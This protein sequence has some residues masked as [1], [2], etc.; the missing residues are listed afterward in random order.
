LGYG[1]ESEPPK[2][3]ALQQNISRISEETL[4]AVNRLLLKEAQDAKIES[5]ERVRI[6]TTPVSGPIHPPT[7]SSLLWDVVRVLVR[8]LVRANAE[9]DLCWSDHTKRAKRR[10]VALLSAKRERRTRLYVDLV[11]VTRRTVCYAQRALA[12]IQAL[13]RDDLARLATELKRTTDLGLKVINQ[14][15]RRV[16]RKEKVPVAD[17]VLSIF[18]PDTDLIV[19]GQRDPVYGHKL[20]VS[21]GASGMILDAVVHDGNPTDSTL[22]VDAVRRLKTIGGTPPTQVAM[23]GGF[24]SRDN[25]KQIKALDVKDVVF[26]K[27]L[28]IAVA[29]MASTPSVF[30]ALRRFRAGVEGCISFLKRCFGLSRCTW[31]GGMPSFKRYVAASVLSANLLVLARHQLA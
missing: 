8:L 6:D 24:S 26:S 29:D 31:K 28:G 20:C 30:R 5:A 11:K 10:T 4:I 12:T 18:E 17:K 21:I 3:A 13:E 2:R 25:L 1:W 15:E 16:I 27:H 22:A 23:D 14:T 7:D 9:V 19:R